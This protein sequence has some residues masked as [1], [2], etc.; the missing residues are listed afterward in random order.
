LTKRAKAANQ[1]KAKRRSTG[2]W[3]KPP[4]KG[5]SQRR[6]KRMDRPAMISM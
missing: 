1:A 5:S 3:K 4:A 2:Q 6:A